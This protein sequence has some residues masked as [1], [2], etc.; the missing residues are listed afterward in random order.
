MGDFNDPIKVINRFLPRHNAILT[1]TF[2]NYGC[3]MVKAEFCMTHGP[4]LCDNVT[5]YHSLT[6]Y[7]MWFL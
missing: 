6:L 4:Y 1:L 2:T 3:K 5:F 7:V